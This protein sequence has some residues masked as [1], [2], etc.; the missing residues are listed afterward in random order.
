MT[1]STNYTHITLNI[2]LFSLQL[3]LR[4]F[5]HHH[6]DMACL[7][8]EQCGRFLLRSPDSH[9]RAKALLE[10][11][12]RKKAVQH[13]DGRQRSLVESALYYANPPEVPQISV[14]VEPPMHL[15]VKKLLY[16]DLNKMN[17]EKVI[18]S[19]NY[20]ALYRR[21]NTSSIAA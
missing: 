11:L 4:D 16:K 18:I 13:L 20:P 8:I 10:I 6:V 17:T 21:E 14:E 12:V 7:C 15:Y 19:N 9:L 3:L 2:F 5:T 1:C